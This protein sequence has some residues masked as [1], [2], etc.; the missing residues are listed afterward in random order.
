MLAIIN[1]EF[2]AIRSDITSRALIL[3]EMILI[4]EHQIFLYIYSW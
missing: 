1:Q 2:K 4:A 3:I